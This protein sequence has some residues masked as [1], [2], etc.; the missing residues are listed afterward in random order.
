MCYDFVKRR[1]K[2]SCQIYMERG[3]DIDIDVNIQRFFEE[4]SYSAA[5][6]WLTEIGLN[7]ILANSE[8]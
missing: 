6:F 1:G 2:K 3:I 7:C 4:E 8:N 5:S